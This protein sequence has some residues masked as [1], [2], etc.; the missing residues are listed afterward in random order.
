MQGRDDFIVP[1][2]PGVQLQEKLRAAGVKAALL[3]LPHADHGFDLL[4]TDWSPAARQAL[5]HAE[6]F[7]ALMAARPDSDS[8]RRV[9]LTALSG[10]GAPAATTDLAAATAR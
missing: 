8:S 10:S 2:G 3:L 9:A 4:G 1:P 5:W 7:L 6:R